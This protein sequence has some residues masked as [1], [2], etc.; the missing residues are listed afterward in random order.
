VQTTITLI[1]VTRLYAL[2]RHNR[3]YVRATHLGYVKRLY[4]KHDNT[5]SS[6]NWYL[7]KIKVFQRGTRELFQCY[8]YKWVNPPRL[9]KC[10]QIG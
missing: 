4:I 7:K 5:G 10:Y 1:N 2:F 6:P 3:F 8:C 9:L